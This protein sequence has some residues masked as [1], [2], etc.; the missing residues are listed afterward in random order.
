MDHPCSKPSQRLQPL[1]AAGVDDCRSIVT[2]ASTVVHSNSS[3]SSKRPYFFCTM[4]TFA[5]RMDRGYLE[6]LLAKNGTLLVKTVRVSVQG[7]NSLDDEQII[8][9][10]RALLSIL[11]HSGKE[12][13][14]NDIPSNEAENGA[15][16]SPHHPVVEVAEEAAVHIP[17]NKTDND[18]SS[19]DMRVNEA[20]KS[21][22]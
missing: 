2:S 10:V 4:D 7:T 18:I 9:S 13:D 8:S 3:N 16:D 12:E 5:Q 20:A 15:H 11:D 21:S 22:S 19:E 1:V 17:S 14:P 6:Y